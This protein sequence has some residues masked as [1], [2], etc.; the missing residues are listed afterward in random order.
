MGRDYT[1]ADLTGR[2]KYVGTVMSVTLA[3]DGWFG[4]GDD[5]FFIDGED[6]GDGDA[7]VP[8]RA[9]AED[10]LRPRA[11]QPNRKPTTAAPASEPP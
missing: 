1:I 2:G 6:V 10:Y 5:F 4:E 7:G 3:Q 9:R 11:N 8:F